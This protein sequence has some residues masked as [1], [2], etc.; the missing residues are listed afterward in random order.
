MDVSHSVTDTHYQ[1]QQEGMVAAFADTQLQQV[2][3]SQPHGV[4]ISV[5]QFSS[6]SEQVIHWHHLR[7]Q[8]DIHVFVQ[9]LTRMQRTDLGGLTGIG[10]AMEQAMQEL[11]QVPCVPEQLVI[12]VS[13]D[14]PSNLGVLPSEMRDQ[15]Q[16]QGIQVNGLPI[17]SVQ[18]HDLA[19]YF[20]DNVVTPDGFVVVADGV[21]DFGRAIRR[22]LTLEIAQR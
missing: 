13:A 10:R 4:M 12:D 9:A 22:K 18:E 21:S 17:V 20:R 6:F 14:G 19:D 2:I 3:L 16:Q 11:E 15:A 1:L 5:Q 8:S 7:N